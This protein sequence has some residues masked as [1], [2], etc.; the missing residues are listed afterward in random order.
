MNHAGTKSLR[1]SVPEKHSSSKTRDVKTRQSTEV[2]DD[3]Q[4]E[5]VPESNIV[6][7]SN[8][9]T[10]GVDANQQQQAEGIPLVVIIAPSEVESST[11]ANANDRTT[12]DF[13]EVYCGSFYALIESLSVLCCK[14]RARR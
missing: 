4:A 13:F 11:D 2:R 6:P 1:K 3:G 14:Y 8:V 12:C 10:E 5:A 9:N 7:A